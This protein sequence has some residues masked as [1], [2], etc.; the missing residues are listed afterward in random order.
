MNESAAWHFNL[1]RRLRQ[2]EYRY[3]E[4]EL[5]LCGERIYC[6]LAHPALAPSVLRSHADPRPDPALAATLAHCHSQGNVFALSPRAG[7]TP[8]NTTQARPRRD[9]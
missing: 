4:L 6:I 3:H 1:G 9:S 2:L 8:D 5:R 7:K